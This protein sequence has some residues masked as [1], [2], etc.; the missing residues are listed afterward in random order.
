GMTSSHNRPVLLVA[1][2]GSL[3]DCILLKQLR[4]FLSIR[5]RAQALRN[6]SQQWASEFGFYRQGPPHPH[7]PGLQEHI[8]P[9]SGSG[10][11]DRR[12]SRLSRRT[13]D[14]SCHWKPRRVRSEMRHPVPKQLIVTPVSRASFGQGRRLN[15]EPED[16]STPLA[17]KTMEPA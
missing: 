13:D 1:C 6:R 9:R 12:E 7:Y 2:V 3:P 11:F 15:V 4:P 5:I 16:F 10:R 17:A 14:D 8:Q